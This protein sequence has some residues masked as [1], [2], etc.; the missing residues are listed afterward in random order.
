MIIDDILVLKF[1]VENALKTFSAE[2]LRAEFLSFATPRR[3]T[4]VSCAKYLK[5]NSNPVQERH[6]APF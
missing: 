2:V 3:Q 6:E 1:V 4:G 5:S